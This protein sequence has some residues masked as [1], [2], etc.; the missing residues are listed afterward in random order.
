MPKPFFLMRPTGPY[1]RFLVP[2]DLREQIGRRFIVRAVRN[3]TGRDE[4]RL[5]AAAM[6]L[7]LS[8]AFQRMRGGVAVADFEKIFK[9]AMNALDSGKAKKWELEGTTPSGTPFKMKTS[10][11]EADRASAERAVASI[12]QTD[13]YA[14]A[15]A[16]I[17]APVTPPE[18][19]QGPTLSKAAADWLSDRASA[20][21]AGNLDQ[22]TF[23]ESAHSLRI[24][25]AVIGD[26]S[27]PLAA[28]GHDDIRAFFNAVMIWPKRAGSLKEYRGKTAV[29]ILAMAKKAK[30]PKR[31]AGFTIKKH[32]SMLAAFF[33]HQIKAGLISKNPVH[34]IANL[35]KPDME[36]DTGRPFTDTELAAIFHPEI[37]KAWAV[38]YPHRWFGVILGLY[39]GA[40]VNE[41]AQLEVSDI[42]EI[43]GV[44]GFSVRHEPEKG[45]KLK[46][47]QSRRFVPLADPVIA[48]GFLNYRND[49]IAAGHNRLFPN[50]PN[51]TGLGFGRSLSR[52][53]CD[54]IHEKSVGVVEEGS[55][56]HYFRHTLASM[57]YGKIDDLTLVSITG[58][59][60]KGTAE[61]SG[62]LKDFYIKK[63]L[64]DRKAA[65]NL[66]NP[67]VSLPVYTPG[68]FRGALRAAPKVWIKQPKKK[69]GTAEQKD[70]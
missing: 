28:V 36:E 62:V 23:I 2:V 39:S 40:R 30:T 20:E 47:K 66:F 16:S 59:T 15:V 52:Q 31:P 19:P 38:K 70:A 41:V 68:Q 17:N 49:V 44:W 4:I 63:T 13:A 67:G 35:P 27:K 55:G 9:G 56:F 12:F 26:A 57:L 46:N 37:F 1:V 54:Y 58:H 5:V 42:E 24:L 8:Q 14:R 60:A 32:R 11:D 18:V 25:E 53:F 21:D 6:G 61:I 29:E 34:G 69:A 65:V 64:P 33:N 45:K 43:H 50:L 3:A 10:D 51:S 7:V 22:K 48:A